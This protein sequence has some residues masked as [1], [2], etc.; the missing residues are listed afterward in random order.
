MSID[1]FEARSGE[2]AV[3][4]REAGREPAEVP[5][6][7][8]GITLVGEDAAALASLERDREASGGSLDIWRG[9]VDDLRRLRDRVAATGATW[10][11]ALAAGPS[12]RLDLIHETLR[13]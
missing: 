5:P 4:A 2:L 3:W 8:A 12:D 10:M 6:T 11:I 9:T 1:A 13:S 7:W